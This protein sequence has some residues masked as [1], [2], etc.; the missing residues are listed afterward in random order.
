MYLKPFVLIF[1][2]HYANLYRISEA[3][4]WIKNAT[5]FVFIGTWFSVNINEIALRIALSTNSTTEII[6]RDPVDL[7]C[8]WIQ[9]HEM[10]ASEY[11]AKNNLYSWKLYKHLSLRLMK[12]KE[13]SKQKFNSDL[14]WAMLFWSVIEVCA[15]KRMIQILFL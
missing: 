7:G 14:C 2:E 11:V 12:S 6:D 4:H 8:N 1:G 13:G 5:N 10:S 3:E 9:F 15:H